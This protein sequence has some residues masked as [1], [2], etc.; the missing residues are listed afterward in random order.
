MF[1]KIILVLWLS[2]T[3]HTIKFHLL[4]YSLFNCWKEMINSSG[5]SGLPM[6]KDNQ[7]LKMMKLINKMIILNGH[8]MLILILILIKPNWILKNSLKIKLQIDGAIDLFSKKNRE[9]LN[10]LINRKKRMN[11]YKLRAWKNN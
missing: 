8:P 5:L 4:G 9:N 2:M 1:I 11:F 6:E 3:Y 7:I 10:F